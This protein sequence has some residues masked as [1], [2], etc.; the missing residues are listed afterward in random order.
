MPFKFHDSY[1]SICISL[2]LVKLG[3][4]TMLEPDFGEQ[5]LCSEDNLKK[6]YFVLTWEIG[7]CHH[8]LAS[9]LVWQL[10]LVSFV[11]K[12]DFPFSAMTLLQNLGCHLNLDG[13]GENSGG[14][15]FL[16]SEKGMIGTL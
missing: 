8:F 5:D 7:L 13:K 1:G 3:L 10:N 15:N 12:L 6:N 14:Y 9:T 16:G 2:N 11:P 4:G